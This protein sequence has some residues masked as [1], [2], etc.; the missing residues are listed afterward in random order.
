MDERGYK[1][2]IG[3]KDIIRHLINAAAYDKVSHAYLFSGEKGSGKKLLASIFAA[4]LNCEKH[5]GEPCFHCT[6]CRKALS[7]N[8]PDIIRVIHEKPDL[9]N[10]REVREQI[11]N[12]VDIKPYE[13]RYKVYIVDEMEKMNPQAQNAI[14]KTIEEPPSYAVILLLA[15]NPDALLSTIQSR[16]VRLNL[17]TVP[18]EDVRQ[19]L[20]KEMMLPDYEA[21]IAAAF[22]QGNIGRARMSVTGDAFAEMAEKAIRLVKKSGKMHIY[23][24]VEAVRELSDDKKNIDTFFDILTLWFRDV[25]LYKAT[26]EAEN[27][28]FR[29]E[30]AEIKREATVCSYEGL[31]E[32]TEAIRKAGARIRANVNF[33]LTIELL[34]LTIGDYLRE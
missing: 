23:E 13:S 10:V 8:H 2:V 31:E 15:N 30:L 24:I 12:T 18:S 22:A 9:I 11:V 7:G 34:F 3:H 21:E 28:V 19:Y 33:E 29:R 14:L 27:L 5:T 6:S 17:K 4:A 25:L 26:K 32:I 16:C 20:M 1:G